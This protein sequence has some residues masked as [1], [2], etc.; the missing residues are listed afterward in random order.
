MLKKDIEDY[1][2]QRI[3]FANGNRKSIYNPENNKEYMDLFRRTDAM[4]EKKRKKNV[5]R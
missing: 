1:N 4:Y 2:Y 3:I 5:E